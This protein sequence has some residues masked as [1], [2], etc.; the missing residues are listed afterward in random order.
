[1]PE[2]PM[3]TRQRPT[4]LSLPRTIREQ[5]EARLGSRVI[6]WASR[7]GGYSPGLASV[8][9]TAN[10]DRVFVKAVHDG[11]TT[12]RRLYQQEAR[13]LAVIPSGV[14]MPQFR[15]SAQIDGDAR[16]DGS[17]PSWVVLAFDAVDGRA[18]HRGWDD[19]ELGAFMRLAHRIGEHQIVPGALPDVCDEMPGGPHL[20]QALRS[21]AEPGNDAT[22]ESPG[23]MAAGL[24]T[25]DPW[26]AANI[27]RLAALAAPAPQAVRGTGLAHC[28]LRGD[29]TL[30]VGQPTSPD[31]V[32]A[33]AVDW[34]YASRG[35][36][37]VDVVAALPSVYLEGGPDPGTV[38]TRHPLPDSTDPGA[39][40]AWL[41]WI[42]GYFVEASLSPAP[43]GIPHLRRFQHA[44]AEVCIAWLRSRLGQ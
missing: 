41:A 2:L 42:T 12:A 36:L 15:W 25:Y 18:P 43:I 7:D 24:A 32:E 1:M 23:Q 11:H 8:L 28:D 35:S 33:V 10:R 30:L 17:A 29:N 13:R 44:Q 27:D 3:A 6:E 9:V 19:G 16:N 34:A 22:T 4:W 40:T 20:W 39:V 5:I 38:L 37:M 21:F 31:G 26:F 14:P